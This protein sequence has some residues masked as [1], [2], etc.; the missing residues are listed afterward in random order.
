MCLSQARDKGTSTDESKREQL[1]C[2][3]IFCLF[4]K[5]AANSHLLVTRKMVVRE[6]FV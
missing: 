2:V 6:H 3:N 4:G 5:G 1:A